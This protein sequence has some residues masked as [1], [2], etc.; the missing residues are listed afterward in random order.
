MTD[1][2]EQAPRTSCPIRVTEANPRNVDAIMQGT[3]RPTL[4]QFYA[5]WCGHCA[6]TRPEVDKASAM[7]CNDADVVRINVDQHSKLA[8]KL[9]VDGLPTM[10]LVEKGKI[11]GRIEGES[12]A[13]ELAAFVRARGQKTA[14]ARAARAP[15]AARKR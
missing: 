13:A 8:D 6:T 15:R 7:L 2:T 11:L 4:V 9:G 10:V 12:T 3:N 1:T 5:N 14:P